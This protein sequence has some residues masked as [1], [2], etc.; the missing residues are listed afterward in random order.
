MMRW[1]AKAERKWR[2]PRELVIIRTMRALSYESVIQCAE[3]AD[4]PKESQNVD[5]QTY[6]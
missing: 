1:I 2:T 6:T 5:T 4:Q 3:R